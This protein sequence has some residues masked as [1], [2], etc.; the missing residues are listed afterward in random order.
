MLR[1]SPLT[2]HSRHLV[3]VQTLDSTDGDA[4]VVMLLPWSKDE[5]LTAREG[6][7]TLAARLGK[8]S[9]GNSFGKRPA[10]GPEGHFC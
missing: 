5:Q 10:P 2:Y 4:L 3:K 7:Y 9:N 8:V 1:L 6:F